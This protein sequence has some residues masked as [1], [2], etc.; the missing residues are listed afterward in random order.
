M[1]YSRVG[2]ARLGAGRPRTRDKGVSHDKREAV[3]GREGVHVTLRL[4]QHVYN[5]RTRRCFEVL[6][7]AFAAVATRADFRVIGLSIQERH[8]H[9]LLEAARRAALAS[10]MKSLENRIA[11]GLNRRMG[12]S[13]KVL[14][15]RYHDHVL[16]TPAEARA[17]IDYV[18]NN[19]R[20][21]AAEKGHILPADFRDPYTIG[22]FGDLIVLPAGTAPM[23]RPPEGW[24]LTSGWKLAGGVT[25]RTRASSLRPTGL[26]PPDTDDDLGPLFRSMVAGA[27]G[28]SEALP[29]GCEEGELV[30]PDLAVG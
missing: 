4:C 21:H 8:L 25:R 7:A 2:G 15:Q 22:Y 20:K 6:H 16:R 3:S 23:V 30:G 9:L 24:L 29:F 10:G 18:L 27:N 1:R 28:G 13:G 12:T 26:V 19:T 17:A 14:D 11:D 5:L